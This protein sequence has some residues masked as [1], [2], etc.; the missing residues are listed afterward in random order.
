MVAAA[1]LHT[2]WRWQL[3]YGRVSGLERP[4]EMMFTLSVVWFLSFSKL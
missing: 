3:I 4:F 2:L 1:L